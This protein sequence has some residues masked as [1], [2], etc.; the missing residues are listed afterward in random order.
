[1]CITLKNI[2]I[3]TKINTIN[4]LYSVTKKVKHV[5]H[6][7]NKITEPLS[8]YEMI[9]TYYP[10]CIPYHSI[11]LMTYKHLYGATNVIDMYSNITTY[12]DIFDGCVNMIR[13]SFKKNNSLKRNSLLVVKVYILMYKVT[14]ILLAMYG[15]QKDA[16][17]Y[18]AIIDCCNYILS[19]L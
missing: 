14:W 17:S 11:I 4:E 2:S 1:M 19:R 8:L 9:N 10:Q 7:Y 15:V 12:K 3:R 18:S 13:K 5:N 6:I 16:L